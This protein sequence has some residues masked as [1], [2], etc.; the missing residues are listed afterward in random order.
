MDVLFAVLRYEK[1]RLVWVEGA[2]MGV[3][4]VTDVSRRKH[5]VVA[6]AL[7]I[8][9]CFCTVVEMRRRGKV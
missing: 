6:V 9:I 5:G 7:R 1:Y 8:Q 3:D 2:Q 4:T